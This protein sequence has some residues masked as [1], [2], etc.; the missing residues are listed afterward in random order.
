VRARSNGLELEYDTFGDPVDPALLLISGFAT[1]MVG[2]EPGFCRMLADDGFYV[3]RFD[4]RDVG[5]SSR[6]AGQVELAELFAGTLRSVPY[7]LDDM[8]DDA[9]GLLD[10]LGVD[11]AHVVGSSMGGMIGQ[12]VAIRHPH[13]VL[14]LCS[15]MSTTGDPGVGQSTPEA[16]AALTMPAATTPSEAARRGVRVGRVITSNAYFDEASAAR[17]AEEAYVRAHD[18]G[19]V[20]RQLAAV[21]TQVDRTPALAG[22]KVPTLVIHG[23]VDPVFHVSGGRATADAVPDARLLV[24]DDMGH[25]LPEPLWTRIT[26]EITANARRAAAS[27]SPDR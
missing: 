23:A 24:I 15:I 26:S 3:I 17:R 27:S 7:G 14:S 5:L 8:A 19:G 2:W 10:A 21:G 9:L 4:N 16:I 25:E 11:A 20:T 12:T 18:P 22:V 6:V 13:R 1:Q